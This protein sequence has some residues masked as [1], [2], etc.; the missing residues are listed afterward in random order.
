M[1]GSYASL[2]VSP[3]VTLPLDNNSFLRKYY[4]Y[5]SEASPQHKS[6]LPITLSEVHFQ[7]TGELGKK[8]GWII[9][10]IIYLENESTL[11]GKFM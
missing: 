5:E 1:V 6:L 11:E 8:S 2:F 9:I 10:H 4:S 7:S 3:S